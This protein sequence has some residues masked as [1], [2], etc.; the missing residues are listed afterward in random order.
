MSG[1]SATVPGIGHS[2]A[3]A[4][5]RDMNLSRTR[6]PDSPANN[7]RH[8][9]PKQIGS[10]HQRDWY[11][12]YAG[13]P[14]TFVDA[15]IEAFIPHGTQI[16]DPWSG[17]GTTTTVCT[18][19]GLRSI[20]I[21][22]NP[23]LTVIARARLVPTSCRESLDQTT[24]TVLKL[25][26]DRPPTLASDDLLT[27]WFQPSA[28]SRIRSIQHA[29]H[30]VHN[31]PIGLPSQALAAFVDRLPP[32]VC[33]LYGALFL[34]VRDFASRFRTTNPTW[35]KR[36]RNYR[37]RAA[38]TWTN[39]HATFQRSVDT[40]SSRLSL[41]HALLATNPSPFR[42][43]S[44]TSLTFEK[45][46]FDALISS[47][48]YATRIDYVTS[49]LPELS[50]LGAT[51][52]QIVSLRREVMGSPVAMEVAFDDDDHLTS[53]TARSLLMTIRDHESKAS[54]AYYLPR[55]RT[56]MTQLEKGLHEANRVVTSDGPLCLVVQDS[57]YKEHKVDLQRIVC[58]VLEG[59]G[60]IPTARIDYPVRTLRSAK[61]RD[62]SSSYPV[63]RYCETLLVFK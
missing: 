56:Y 62:G 26:R 8:V 44:A 52:H 54:K 17:S 53:E 39:V 6:A 61:R 58:E 21:D 14:E 10:P 43:G 20:G 24:A 55:M 32:G 23:A 50:V 35:F 57:Y 45:D 13:Y 31:H 11:P 5:L 15:V 12:Y 37:K 36:P 51:R 16:L 25:A 18:K 4:R 38:P 46:S 28:A 59:A 9:S 41:S 48:P 33:F 63:R 3:L 30:S 47:P 29:I 34:T 27:H 1:H 22:I 7:L 42:T 60:R 2:G 49:T 40:L 19:R